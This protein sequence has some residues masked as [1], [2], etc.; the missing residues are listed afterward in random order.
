MRSAR[1]IA[2]CSPG[3]VLITRRTTTPSGPRSSTPQIS[4][5]PRISGPNWNEWQTVSATD[6]M[7]SMTWSMSES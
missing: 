5:S 4:G 1:M 2:H 3:R 6:L 7:T